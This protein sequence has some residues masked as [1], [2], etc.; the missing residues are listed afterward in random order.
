LALKEWRVAK[1]MRPGQ[2]GAVKL[3]RLHGPDL[4]CVRYRESLD[5]TE[6]LTTVEVVVE[7]AVIQCR[8]D[9]VVAFKL[10]PEEVDLRHLAMAKGA[11]YDPRT[12]LW[13]LRRSEVIRMGLRRRIA[14]TTD[15]LYQELFHR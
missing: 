6:R 14:V 12:S 10:K 3:T 2:R 15:E 8:S 13:K 1:T 11:R 4:V 9:P 5:G 7:R